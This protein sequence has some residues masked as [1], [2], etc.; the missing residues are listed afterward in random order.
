MDSEPDSRL[1]SPAWDLKW[2]LYGLSNRIIPNLPT[3][4]LVTSLDEILNK[5]NTG[6]IRNEEELEKVLSDFETQ[7]AD[8]LRPQSED[9]IR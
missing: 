3:D 7:N 5:I 4:E 1:D 9:D 8:K 6:E 2:R